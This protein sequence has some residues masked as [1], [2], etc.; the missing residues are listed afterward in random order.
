[1][2]S[3]AELELVLGVDGMVELRALA[4]T[5]TRA[6]GFT[7]VFAQCNHFGIRDR[8][9]EQLRV[10]LLGREP[11]IIALPP[12]TTDVRPELLS[13]LPNGAPPSLFV[14]G[15][16]KSLDSRAY[17]HPVLANLN[18]ARNH[19]PEE[20]PFP[21]VFWLPEFAMR[22]VAQ[23]AP[24][25]WSWRS[26]AYA[27]SAPREDRSDFAGSLLGAGPAALLN[28]PLDEKQ[29]R[30]AAVR[31]LLREYAALDDTDM[32]RRARAAL[33]H[34]AGVLSAALGDASSAQQDFISALQLSRQMGDRLGIGTFL[35]SLGM[36]HKRR[37][38]Y[39]LAQQCLEESLTI[40]R[41]AG[42]PAAIAA[43]LHELGSVHLFQGRYAEAQ[44]CYEEA[45]DIAR[46]LQDQA[47]IASS[48]P[49]GYAASAARRVRASAAVLRGIAGDSTRTARSAHARGL[50][51][52]VGDAAPS[53]RRVR[54]G[55]TVL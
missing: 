53:S 47:A 50:A 23:Q 51:S 3:L 12:E 24:D 20:F 49:A 38:D 21:V 44:R 19:L 1:M 48:W 40:A 22:I 17:F 11:L 27:F 41:N 13:R 10:L 33:L 43:S 2:T 55:T 9:M 4:R 46:G 39:G 37:G 6:E 7:L 42:S 45:L 14:T 18:A 26:A 25:L 30:L 31:A 32:V 28:L 52:P 16:E 34:Q 5:L 15:L 8:I 54:A 36:V 29:D 35:H